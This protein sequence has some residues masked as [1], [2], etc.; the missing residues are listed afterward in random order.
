MMKKLLLILLF[1]PMIGF[2]QSKGKMINQII[3]NT[4]KDIKLPYKSDYTLWY[5]VVNENN[6]SIVF[7]HL[8]S[9]KDFEKLG[10]TKSRLISENKSTPFGKFVGSNN[11]TI[12]TR[13][14]NYDYLLIKE[15]KISPNDWDN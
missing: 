8:C 13:Y 9:E 4:K 11:I 6:E 5:D 2:G 14:R 15:I 7:L 12:V 10:M 1:L 3:E